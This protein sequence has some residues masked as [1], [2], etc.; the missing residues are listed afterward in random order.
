MC[1][2]PDDGSQVVPDPIA[3][4]DMTFVSLPPTLIP[5]SLPFITIN[6]PISIEPIPGM[7]SMV[8]IPPISP[9]EGLAMGI[10]IFIFC[11]GEACGFG[12]AVGICMPGIFICVC[13]DAEGDACGICIP[14]IFICF[15]GDV[16]GVACGI[17][18]PGLFI[19]I[20]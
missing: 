1:I 12:E 7:F 16:E 14:G 6:G 4:M 10:G 8:F 13:G 19:C 2:G 9:G 15:C 17:C 11:S 3:P 18:I 5:M 20:C